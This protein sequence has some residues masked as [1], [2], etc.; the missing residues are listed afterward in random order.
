MFKNSTVVLA[1]FLRL[2]RRGDLER[3]LGYFI[4]SRSLTVSYLKSAVENI[5]EILKIVQWYSRTATLVKRVHGFTIILKHR[6]IADHGKL[7]VCG[8]LYIWLPYG[9]LISIDSCGIS[10][11]GPRKG[12]ASIYYVLVVSPFY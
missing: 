1:D 5:V 11:A 10:S 12:H 6:S 2:P 3:S 4:S 9:F 8:K 7:G